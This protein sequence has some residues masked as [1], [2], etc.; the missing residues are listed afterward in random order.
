MILEQGCRPMKDEKNILE[1][2][3][4]D[5]MNANIPEAERTE[6]MKNLLQLKRSRRST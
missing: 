5:I 4:T 2:M 1:A 6:L 3:E